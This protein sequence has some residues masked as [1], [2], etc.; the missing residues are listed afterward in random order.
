MSCWTQHWQLHYCG[1]LKQNLS[2]S[3]KMKLVREKWR[4]LK[5]RREMKCFQQVVKKEKAQNE[6]NMKLLICK[7]KSCYP[8]RITPKRVTSANGA[9]ERISHFWA[10]TPR[11]HAFELRRNIAAV[12]SRWRHWLCPLRLVQFKQFQTPKAFLRHHWIF[13]VIIACYNCDINTVAYAGFFNGRGFSDATSCWCKNSTW[14]QWRR[15]VMT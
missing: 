12:T 15:I 9:S 4:K 1:Y 7:I 13:Q 3:S 8:H 10:E 14:R 2:G 6:K 5:L 11:Q